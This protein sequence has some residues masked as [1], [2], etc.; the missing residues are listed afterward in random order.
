MTF[1]EP[2]D[3]MFSFNSPLGACERCE[4]FGRVMGISEE[5]VVPDTSKSLYDGAVM[6]W[7]GEKMGE[8]KTSLYVVVENMKM[9]F[10]YLSHT[11]N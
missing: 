5:L 7:R 11:T 2:D 4:G 6:C 3:N 8:W 1:R 10:L 9:V